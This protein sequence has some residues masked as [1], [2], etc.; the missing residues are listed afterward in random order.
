MATPFRLAAL[1]HTMDKGRVVEW[2]VVEGGNVT[3]GEPLLAVETDKANR[4]CGGAGERRAAE[5]PSASG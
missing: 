1:G 2:F 5:G 3:E 4:R